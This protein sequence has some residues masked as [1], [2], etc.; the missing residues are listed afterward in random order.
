MT[1]NGVS[2]KL[3]AWSSTDRKYLTM[4]RNA[5]PKFQVEV[6]ILVESEDR[7]AW[8]RTLRGVQQLTCLGFPATHPPIIWRDM[9]TSRFQPK[10]MS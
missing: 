8:Q 7:I 6:G 5:C 3:T 1:E 4:L 10:K 2:A 9:G